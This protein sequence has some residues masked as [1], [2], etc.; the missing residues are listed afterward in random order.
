MHYTLFEL[1]IQVA[2]VSVVE[3]L[4]LNPHHS[5]FETIKTTA[6]VLPILFDP[7]LK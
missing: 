3:M 2:Q 6:K 4:L 1:S 7:R 5:D